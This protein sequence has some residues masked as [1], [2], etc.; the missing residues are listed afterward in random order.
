M[1]EHARRSSAPAAPAQPRVAGAARARA[2]D[3]A[4]EPARAPGR[5]GGQRP[6]PAAGRRAGRG[7]VALSDP[8]R[9]RA[10]L[11][12]RGDPRPRDPPPPRRARRADARP[13]ASRW[14]TSSRTRA[15]T[16]ASG[17]LYLPLH[18][19]SQAASALLT[20]GKPVTV[21]RVHDFNLLEQTWIAIP[22]SAPH[23][24]RASDEEVAETLAAFGV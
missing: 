13:R 24:P 5:P 19:L 18:I 22:S 2:L 8:R 17:P 7:R 16:I 12:R 3:A 6:P 21:S 23:A 20:R 9:P 11:G 4:D 10:R 14:R 15:S 1:T